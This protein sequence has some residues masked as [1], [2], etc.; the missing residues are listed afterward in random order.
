MS[1]GD[2]TT[3]TQTKLSVLPEHVWMRSGCTKQVKRWGYYMEDF[4][5]LPLMKPKLKRNRWAPPA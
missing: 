4:H 3:M 2:V 5:V 1:Y